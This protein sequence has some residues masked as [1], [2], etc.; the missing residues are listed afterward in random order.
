MSS[1]SASTVAAQ[2]DD[3][4]PPEQ[5]TFLEALRL[6]FKLGFLGFGGPAAQNP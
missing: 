1:N 3:G 6:W 4:V 5:V 2:A